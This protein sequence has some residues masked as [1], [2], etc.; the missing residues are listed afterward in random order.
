MAI[1]NDIEAKF[2]VDKWIISDV[3][4]WPLIRAQL[5]S[6]MNSLLN[7]ELDYKLRSGLI[8]LRNIRRT[9]DIMVSLSKYLYAVIFDRRHNDTIAGQNIDAFFLSSCID[10]VS[11]DKYFYNKL[12][13]PLIEMLDEQGFKSLVI[14]MTWMGQYYIPRYKPSKYV[15]PYLDHLLLKNKLSQIRKPSNN[16]QLSRYDDFAEYLKALNSSLTVPIIISLQKEVALIREMASYFKKIIMQ[17]RPAV[18]LSTQYYGRGGM[19]LNLACRE[20][21]IMSVDIQHGVQDDLHWAYGRWARVPE[22]GYELLPTVFL[23]WSDAEAKV[24]KKWNKKVKEYHR[25]VVAGNLWLKKWLDSGDDTVRAYDLRVSRM[26]QKHGKL[27]HI[28]FTMQ[29]KTIPSV[30]LNA[31]KKSSDLCFWWIRC[32]P[33]HAEERSNIRKAISSRG[34]VNVEVE[35]ASTL[36]LYALLRHVDIHITGWSTTVIEAAAFNVQSIII[37]EFGAEL[38]AKQIKEDIVACAYNSQELVDAIMAMT[39]NKPRK[40]K[41]KH[42]QLT[43]KENIQMLFDQFKHAR[44]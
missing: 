32:H 6:Q 28:L 16:F 31:I 34:Y 25:P 8:A 4:V 21:G 30:I 5:V 26:K 27:I 29:D 9:F 18:C 44:N 10:R 3:H 1:I 20:M 22:K 15:Q 33:G 2:P 19:A 14:E 43:S 42:A 23:C 13:D 7:K 39:S 35:K 17:V 37:H 36:P 11:I 38:Y 41:I 24:I 12:V 40:L